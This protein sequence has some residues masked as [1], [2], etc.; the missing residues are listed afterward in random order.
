MKRKVFG[1]TCQSTASFVFSLW[2]PPISKKLANDK[3]FLVVICD[4]V[5]DMVEAD[6]HLACVPTVAF[7]MD[8]PTAENPAQET[9]EKDTNLN[10]KHQRRHQKMYN[11]LIFPSLPIKLI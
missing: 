7:P 8:W 10:T 4:A 2:Q 1:W 6:P 5:V 11:P 9:G 3:I